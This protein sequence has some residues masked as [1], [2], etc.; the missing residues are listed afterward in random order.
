MLR[1]LLRREDGYVLPLVLGIGLVLVLIAA[2]TLAS[3][4]SGER[5]ADTETDWNAALAAAYAG[6]EDYSS[7]VAND[8]SYVKFGNPASPFSAA[9]TGLSLPSGSNANPAFNI[10]AGSDWATVPGSGGKAKFRYEVETSRYPSTGV[11][12]LRATG[13]VGE[14]TRS[15]IADL[16]QDGFSDFVYFTDFETS[17][18]LVTSGNDDYCA[19]YWWNRPPQKTSGVPGYGSGSPNCADIQFAGSDVIKGKVHTNDRLY[20]CSATFKG[21][22]TTASTT[23]PLYGTASGC[24]APT[25]GAGVP[26]KVGAIL[27]P[28]TNS[29][30]RK[31]ARNDLPSEV[32][33]PGC[34]YTGP[35]VIQ[36]NANGT[37]TVWSPFT[38]KT[39]VAATAAGAT[40]PAKC[41]AP[42]T[43]AGQ[44]GSTGGATIPVLDLNLLFVQNIPSSTTDPNYPTTA[45]GTSTFRYNNFSCTGT[46]ASSAWYIGS[47]TNVTSATQRFPMANEVIPSSSTSTTPAYGCKNGDLYIKGT[48]SGRMTVAAENYVYVTGDIGYANPVE[49]MIGVVG[50]NAIWVWNPMNSSNSALLGNNRTINASLLSV[51]HTIQVQNY[52]VGSPRGTLK[53][54]GSMAQKFRGPVGTGTSTSI[55][56]GYAKDYN[57]DARLTY[58]A[59]PKY[60]TPTSTTYSTSQIAGVPSAFD[61]SGAP[62]T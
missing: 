45:L 55:S 51:A 25:F 30:M 23:S 59:P 14:Q 26:V 56:T 46:S 13:L 10:T 5:K 21:A 57:Y 44:L 60:L 34:L 43:A 11:I 61:A 29:E 24:S 50:Q 40:T 16:R 12:R 19:N 9:S 41:G 15:V 1:R 20:L 2:T 52:N 35:T 17:D 48:L 53:I 36:L 6:V 39:Q 37:M 54:V 22:V 32:P 8:P 31:E 18:P 4:V 28:A 62:R 47:T 58:S 49:D 33:D 27:M 3:T 38:R 7:R 42:G